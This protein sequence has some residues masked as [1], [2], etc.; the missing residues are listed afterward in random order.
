MCDVFMKDRR[1]NEEF[2]KLV[3]LSLSRLSLEV[4]C[5]IPRQYVLRCDT[6]LPA[7]DVFTKSDANKIQLIKYA[8][9]TLIIHTYT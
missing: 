2:I 1:T 7:K 8:L 9:Y 6:I 5:C 4:V 3:E